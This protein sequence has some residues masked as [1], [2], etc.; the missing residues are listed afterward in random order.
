MPY[1]SVSPLLS[2]AHAPA[3]RLVLGLT[4]LCG[5]GGSNNERHQEQVTELDSKCRHL[6]LMRAEYTRYL[7]QRISTK[8]KGKTEGVSSVFT[9]ACLIAT[10]AFAGTFSFLPFYFYLFTYYAP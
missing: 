1:R 6:I 9:V 8:V 10:L 7:W 4:S 5:C 3:K 2:Y